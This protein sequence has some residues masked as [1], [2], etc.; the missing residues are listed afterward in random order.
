MITK[1]GEVCN[2]IIVSALFT[3]I[4]GHRQARKEI[5]FLVLHSSMLTLKSG[6]LEMPLDIQLLFRHQLQAVY[7]D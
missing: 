7:Y 5:S 3:F 1:V 2:P 6:V 4:C